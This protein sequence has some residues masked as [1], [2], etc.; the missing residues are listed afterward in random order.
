MRPASND[1]HDRA[2]CECIMMEAHVHGQEEEEEAH[3]VVMCHNKQ[4]T[5]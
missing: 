3:G 1:I 4:T 2:S 5:C